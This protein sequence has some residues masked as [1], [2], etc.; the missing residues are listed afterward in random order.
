MGK[1]TAFKLPLK[2]MPLGTQE[3]EYE[4]TTE[5]FKDM[6]SSD[7]KKGDV[8]VVLKV[9]NKGD[10]FHLDFTLNGVIFIP[11]DRCLDDMEH[12]VDT[13]YHLTVK[14]GDKY[15]DEK[16][17]LLVI[18]QSEACLNVSYIIYDTVMLTIPL[19][20]VHPAGMCNKAM[21]AKLRKL[22]ARNFDDNDEL[23][24]GGFDDE[25]E[26]DIDNS[27]SFI[28]PRWEALKNLNDNN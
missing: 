21:S 27:D 6:E 3:F 26:E 7:V 8:K 20:H 24:E 11:C 1:L 23:I 22:T 25:L 18:P 15:S 5:F 16:D 28:D 19:K 9:N 14:Y 17:D 2:G 12:I 10:I 4:L 13:T